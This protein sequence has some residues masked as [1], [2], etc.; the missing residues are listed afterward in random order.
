MVNKPELLAPAGDLEK[1]KIAVLYGADA[2]YLG[3]HAFSLRAKAKN[4]GMDELQEGINFAHK[5][6][7]KVYVTANIFAHDED[8]ENIEEY[9]K[10]L[11][12]LG[13]DAL[14]ISD[15]GIFL[16]ARKTVPN[17][18]IH[19]STQANV[20]NTQSAM[21]WHNLGAKRV[22]LARELTL[23]EIENLVKN[24]PSTLSAEC[25]VHGA[26]CISYSGRCLLSSYFN[27]R[28]SNRGNC[29]QPCRWQYYLSEQSRPNELIPIHET[30]NGT[31]IL[32]STDLCMIEYVPQ[33][34]NAGISSFK[35][36][37][38]MKTTHYVAV[39][40]KAYR[41]AIDDYLN[42]LSDYENNLEYYKKLVE[43]VSH[44]HYSTGFYFKNPTQIFD[45]SSYIRNMDFV[46]MV[47]DYLPEERLALV[48]QR[49]KFSVGDEIDF[50]TPKGS[51][52][53][54]I[55]KEIYDENRLPIKSAPHAQQKV[56]VKVD[57][58]V[59]PYDLLR[60]YS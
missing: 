11:E 39:V 51:G 9:F 46:G 15:P 60:I 2:V 29:S 5:H 37:G 3:G 17:M 25:F 20:T 23:A 47:I 28:D 34:V 57:K 59:K 32:N 10:Q 26:M 21:F 42:S 27:N 14:I 50:L 33:L 19:I 31:F 1:L 22:I 43:Q 18:E 54:Q 40:V 49:N 30:E 35:I 36:E 58:P 12:M 44:R 41:Q 6:N 16:I 56:M 4:F 7:V 55:I 48:E 8:M 45:S 24:I 13:V 38:R 52:F 53:T